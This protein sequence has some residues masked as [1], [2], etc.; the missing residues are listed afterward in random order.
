MADV[1]AWM[2]LWI[3]DYLA[4]TGNLMAEEHG[5]YLM[6]LMAMWRAGGT[7]PNDGDQLRRFA[8]VGE[9]RWPAVWKIVSPFFLI[10]GDS[11]AQRR[12]TTE[13]EKATNRH[14][15]F[16]ARGKK[17]ARGKHAT[18]LLEAENKHDS[19]TTQA[20][21][22]LCDGD[23]RSN[24]SPSLSPS[25]QPP[26]PFLGSDRESDREG[27]YWT[28]G[29]WLDRFRIA[30]S[31]KYGAFY[32]KGTADGKATGD[33]ADALAAL[34]SAEVA[35]AQSRSA[36]MFAEYLAS[37]TPDLT[38]ARHPFSWFVVRWNGLRVPAQAQSP[39]RA[40]GHSPVTAGKDYS[41][42]LDLFKKEGAAT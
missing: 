34:S 3:G 10:I 4:D 37:E 17:G 25:S 14:I 30:W 12:L 33:L 24:P 36:A 21:P 7:L 32:G 39:A 22:A 23:L 13:L 29:N 18:S 9:K 1:D 26:D 16:S 42:G 27:V 11:I 28:A 15:V 40:K 5:A 8:R 20:K 2:P 19:G 31:V 38:N 6:L 41:A 35:Q